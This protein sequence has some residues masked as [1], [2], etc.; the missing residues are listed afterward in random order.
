MD[1]NP[2][3]LHDDTN[4]DRECYNEQLEHNSESQENQIVEPWRNLLAFWLLGLCNNF[5]YVVMLSA[6]HDILSEQENKQK[7]EPVHKGFHC[8]SVS[9]G[10]ILLADILPCLIVKLTAP[11]YM[12]K[13]SYH[14]RVLFCIVMFAASLIIVAFSKTIAVSLLG[15]VFASI[16]AG[17]G[18]ITFLSFSAHYSKTVISFW[19]SG[20][21]MAG[22]AG[23]LS[24]AALTQL[25]LSSRNTLLLLLVVALIWIIAFWGILKIPNY[26]SLCQKATPEDH[27][28]L[29][30]SR[31]QDRTVNLPLKMKLELMVPLLKYMIPLFL[32]YVAEYTINQGLYELLY[33]DSWLSQSQQYRW[34]QVDYQ[35]AVFISRSSI[36]FFPIKKIIIPTLMQFAILVILLVEACVP[37]L[38]YIWFTLGIVF[39]EGLCG[40]AVYVNAFTLISETSESDTKEFRMGAA[41]M[42]DSLGISVAGAISISIHNA[43]CKLRHS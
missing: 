15:V 27:P 38:H 8:N 19:S 4:S 43:I 32:V 33:Y 26:L 5:G 28:L 41:S 16:S 24:Y 10:S 35:L 20:T 17:V 9:T 7:D 42:A 40:G 34:Y 29:N 12:Q 23:S 2:K 3:T 1:N 6:A 39:L 25:G 30:K 22:L 11:F 14:I 13:V 31:L 21:G 18:E 36:K 37:F